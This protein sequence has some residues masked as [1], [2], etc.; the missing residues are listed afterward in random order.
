MLSMFL[1]PLFPLAV[2]GA[3]CGLLY[4]FSDKKRTGIVNSLGLGI[5]AFFWQ[6]CLYTMIVMALT[7]Y[8]GVR[9]VIERIALISVIVYTIVCSI[10]LAMGIQW[11][12]RAAEKKTT[13]PFRASAAGLGFGVGNV[14]WNIVVPYMIGLYTAST[15]NME[16]YE[17]SDETAASVLAIRPMDVMMDSLKSVCFL[18]IYT[19]MGLL[20]GKLCRQGSRK[21]AFLM[22]FLAMFFINITNALLKQ[23]SYQK[24]AASVVIHV[25]L[26]LLAAAAAWMLSQWLR[27]SGRG[28]T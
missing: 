8:E 19:A 11:A 20:I 12:V 13:S 25:L 15:I 10:F 27:T 7:E 28:N 24:M 9:S 22:T 14:I 16:V 23:F 26:L 6:Q 2:A 1:A 18:F 21:R 5:L 17:G 3:G 4:R